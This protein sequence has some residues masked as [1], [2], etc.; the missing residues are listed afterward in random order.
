MIE[1]VK[2][3]FVDDEKN[4]L[5]SLERLLMDEP[6]EI[7]TASSGPEGLEVLRD[8]GPVQ[9]VISDYRMPEMTGVAFLRE[10]CEHW[11]RT[12]RIVLSG[13]ADTAA[14][15][16]A[17]N[18]GQIYKFIPKPWNDD[19]LKV[20]VQNAVDLCRLH[21]E[22]IRLTE[23]LQVMNGELQRINSNLEHLVAERTAELQFQNAAL[24]YS[25]HILASL[26]VGVVGMAENGLVVQCNDK[27]GRLLQNA[28]LGSNRREVLEPELND[29][30]DHMTDAGGC[31][32]VEIQGHRAL[33]M[34]G[35]IPRDGLQ[36]GVI[37]VLVE[38]PEEPCEH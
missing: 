5:R 7:L 21:E 14:I 18:M 23:D 34:A 31:R 19:E 8:Q 33:A 3:L 12:V 10:V 37:L 29:L 27:A 4:V 36:E 2:V 20:T 32:K 28:R 16:D 17:I 25:Q 6:Y 13:Y 24:Q 35:T 38:C 9:V 1:T 26:P 11:P 30:L 22:N 15:V